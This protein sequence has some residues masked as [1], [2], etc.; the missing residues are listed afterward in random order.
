MPALTL[1]KLLQ[2][3]T[4][5]TATALYYSTTPSAM[6]RQEGDPELPAP[7]QIIAQVAPP[8]P[9]SSAP[10]AG[11]H[12]KPQSDINITPDPA[13]TVLLPPQDPTAASKSDSS[14]CP[15]LSMVGVGSLSDSQSRIDTEVLSVSPHD[16]NTSSPEEVQGDKHLELQPQDEI[17]VDSMRPMTPTSTQDW[18]NMSSGHVGPSTPPLCQDSDASIP[19]TSSSLGFSQEI[20]D[21][22]YKRAKGI[23]GKTRSLMRTC[24]KRM[25]LVASRGFQRGYLPTR[26]TRPP[27]RNRRYSVDVN[28][29]PNWAQ[30]NCLQETPLVSALCTGRST[31]V[32]H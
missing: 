12:T 22:H 4:T 32:L 30:F 25:S 5:R 10:L 20:I 19:M 6:L 8:Q 29:A 27:L 13:D 28:T 15:V 24:T 31:S 3:S 17:C 7:A 9:L 1:W 18:E 21:A 16:D 11:A 26:R 2:P 14:L 23:Y